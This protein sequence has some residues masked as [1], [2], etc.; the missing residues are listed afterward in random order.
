MTM[1]GRKRLEVKV[2]RLEKLVANLVHEVS[3]SIVREKYS[4]DNMMIPTGYCTDRVPFKTVFGEILT[5]MRIK[6]DAQKVVFDAD[7]TPKK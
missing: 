1:F 6:L 2:E 3:N 4:Y 5:R 7:G